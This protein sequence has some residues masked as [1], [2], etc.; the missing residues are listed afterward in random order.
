MVDLTAA[1]SR[2]IAGALSCGLAGRGLPVAVLQCG[3][4]GVGTRA[5]GPGHDQ[6]VELTVHLSG[7]VRRCT[8]YWEEEM[9]EDENLKSLL[10]VI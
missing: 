6:S 9:R 3:H 4:V 10:S 2:H 5:L 8:R 7:G 1:D